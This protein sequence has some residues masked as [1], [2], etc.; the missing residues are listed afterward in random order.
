MTQFKEL[1]FHKMFQCEISW[2]NGGDNQLTTL[3]CTQIRAHM[4]KWTY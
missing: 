4:E 3:W 2:E 1:I